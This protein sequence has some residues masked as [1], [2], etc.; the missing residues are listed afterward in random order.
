MPT[1]EEVCQSTAKKL[2]AF[3]SRA[4]QLPVMLGFDGFVDSIIRVVDQRDDVQNFTVMQTI[5]QFAQRVA[6][7]AGQSSNYELVV[8]R[9]KLGGNGPIM[10]NA[11][12]ALGFP[13][14]YVGAL[15]VPHI[16][17]VFDEFTQRAQCFS[18]ANPGLTDALEFTDGKLMLGKLRTLDQVNWQSLVEQVGVE[19]FGKLARNAHLIGMLNWTMLPCVEEIWRHMVDEILPASNAAGMPRTKMFIDFADPEKRPRDDL[20]TAL[21]LLAQMQPHADVMLGMNL[22]ESQQVAQVL[23]VSLPL[24]EITD[25]VKLAQAIRQSLKITGV[26]IHPRT[27]AAVSMLHGNVESTAWFSGPMLKE[28]KIQTGGGDHFNA[29][30]CCGWLA[31][32]SADE[33]LCS[34]TATSGYYVGNAKT[35]SCTDI[36]ELVRSNPTA[37]PPI[38]A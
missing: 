1:R 11:L 6:Q 38:L 18:L 19:P 30:F 3:Q 31:G 9:E 2:A 12:A 17:P 13:V 35:P 15:G 5:G 22:K 26:V 37:A 20:Q 29:G 32:L 23:D 36:I 33:A 21:D 28:V 14:A 7:A 10:A 24:Q 27:S 4:A 34:G 16:H 8:E 25:V